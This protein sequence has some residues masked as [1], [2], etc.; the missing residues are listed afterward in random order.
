MITMIVTHAGDRNTPFNRRDW[1]NIYFPVLRRCW[2]P[3]G[4]ISVASFFPPADGAGIIAAVTFRD[5]QAMHVALSSP[6]AERV[7]A[8]GNLVAS[9]QAQ[10]G[11]AIPL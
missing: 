1:V 8:D 9:V 4:L 3:Y 7:M 11:L 5:E 2:G 10:R 6:E